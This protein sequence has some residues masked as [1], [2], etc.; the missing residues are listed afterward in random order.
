MRLFASSIVIVYTLL[1]PNGEVLLGPQEIPTAQKFSTV[2]ECQKFVEESEKLANSLVG[3]KDFPGKTE[4]MI[5][6]R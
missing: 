3:R 4:C 5:K 2:E 1:G 6:E